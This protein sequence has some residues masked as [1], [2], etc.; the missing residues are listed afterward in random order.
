M[1][2]LKS[3][4]TAAGRVPLLAK[5][6]KW[7]RRKCFAVSEDAL[8]EAIY[9]PE[10]ARLQEQFG[11][12]EEEPGKKRL[13]DP[14]KYVLELK[15]VLRQNLRLVDYLGLY[16]RPSMDIL[17]LGCGPGYF[18]KICEML[19]HRV[20]GL[21]I[22]TSKIFR[23]VIR[24][25]QLRRVIVRIEPFTPLPALETAP[26]DLITAFAICFNCHDTPQLWTA[27]EWAFFLDDINRFL[28][29]G[30]MLHLWLNAEHGAPEGQEYYT[31][32][33]RD[34]FLSRG[35]RIDGAHVTLTKKPSGCAGGC[36]C[37]CR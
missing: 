15:R 2:F 9:T 32:E 20:T 36:C 25:L 12:G 35:A 23:K 11:Q 18:M 24:H 16:G 14:R 26:Y 7:M 4:L 30:G 33:L 29:P 1:S 5:P 22:D 37:E 19:G 31:P 6:T 21:D 28:K 27:K 8:Y 17:D 13:R 10:F 34:F 3:L